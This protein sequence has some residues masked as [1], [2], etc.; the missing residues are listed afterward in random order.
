MNGKNALLA[1]D[2]ARSTLG[3]IIGVLNAIGVA[4]AEGREDL[5]DDELGEFV[6]ADDAARAR[7]ETKITAARAAGR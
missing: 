5:T 4:H 3:S 2:L 1:I 6:A 7:L